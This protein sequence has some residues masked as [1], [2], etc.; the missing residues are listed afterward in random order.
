M[1]SGVLHA[2]EVGVESSLVVDDEIV[3]MRSGPINPY[4]RTIQF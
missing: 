2:A 1:D 4:A 3:M